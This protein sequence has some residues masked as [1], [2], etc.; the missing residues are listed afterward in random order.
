VLH[1]ILNLP[2]KFAS[3]R[4]ES[5]LVP[6]HA[7]PAVFLDILRGNWRAVSL[8]I[9]LSLVWSDQFFDCSNGTWFEGLREVPSKAKSTQLSWTVTLLAKTEQDGW[10]GGRTDRGLRFHQF[11]AERQYWS[12]STTLCA[13]SNQHLV[14]SAAKLVPQAGGF[15]ARR[16]CWSERPSFLIGG[17]S[18][19]DCMSTRRKTLCR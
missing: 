11:E 7:N 8:F 2:E 18:I 14:C 13:H 15:Y 1:F 19:A 5:S 6:L 4:R 12:A 17:L 3:R 10:M 16:T 9:V